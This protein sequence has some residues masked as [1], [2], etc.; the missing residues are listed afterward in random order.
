MNAY[1]IDLGCWERGISIRLEAK[2]LDACLAM[3]EGSLRKEIESGT[4]PADSIIVQ[5]TQDGRAIYDYMN[6]AYNLKP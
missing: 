3:A 6:G 1:D 4:I 5:I 2:D